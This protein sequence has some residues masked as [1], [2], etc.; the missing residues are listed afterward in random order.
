[1]PIGGPR[2]KASCLEVH[3]RPGAEP[4]P[5]KS[6]GQETNR[7]PGWSSKD[8]GLNLLPGYLAWC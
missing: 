7:D 1:M 4:G 2:S 6:R 8:G 5:V 3:E